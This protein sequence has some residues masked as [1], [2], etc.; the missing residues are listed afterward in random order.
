MFYSLY[1]IRFY[2][3]IVPPPHPNAT[4]KHPESWVISVDSHMTYVRASSGQVCVIACEI[5]YCRL[6]LLI[7]KTQ[8]AV[9][10]VKRPTDLYI[11]NRLPS[12]EYTTQFQ[13]D[14]I[15]FQPREKFPDA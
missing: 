12:T 8:N 9:Y 5:K 3:A 2:F 15:I 1:V 10:E 11:Y 14:S 4:H 7:T 13:V 6:E